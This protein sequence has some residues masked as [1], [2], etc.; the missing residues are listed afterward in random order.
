MKIPKSKT[1]YLKSKTE[2][3]RRW[4]SNGCVHFGN[5]GLILQLCFMSFEFERRCKEIILDREHFSIKVD[6]FD[7]FKSFETFF[8]TI[9]L[10][11]LQRSLLDSRVLVLYEIGG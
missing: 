4:S 1:F 2:F 5:L 6:S 9:F 8:F 11:S 3:L 10:K 7:V